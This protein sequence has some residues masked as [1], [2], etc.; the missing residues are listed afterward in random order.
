MHDHRDGGHDCGEPHHHQDHECRDGGGR[1]SDRR[2][3][4]GGGPDT[5]FLQL[6]M[7][8]VL[9]S[10]AEAAA[11]QA[12]REL[13]VDAAK[14]RWRERFGEQITA[15]AYAAVDELLSDVWASLEIEGRIQERNDGRDTHDRVRHILA[16]PASA[17]R[18][19]RP[20]AGASARKRKR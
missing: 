4:P 10:E 15:L 5:R 16:A 12:V 20:A 6:E 7:S 8:E 3:G 11:K 1:G 19:A 2:D 18:T 17:Q 9:Y 13:F 14:A